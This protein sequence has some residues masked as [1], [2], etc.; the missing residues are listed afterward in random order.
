MCFLSAIGL[1]QAQSNWDVEL[2]P[3]QKPTDLKETASSSLTSDNQ[4]M[5]TKNEKLSEVWVWLHSYSHNWLIQGFCTWYNNKREG[6]CRRG[7]T[8]NSDKPVQGGGSC[9]VVGVVMTRWCLVI[10]P[11]LITFS[12]ECCTLWVQGTNRLKRKW[13]QNR[14]SCGN[15]RFSCIPFPLKSLYKDVVHMLCTVMWKS[16]FT[17]F[18]LWGFYTIR[19]KQIWLYRVLKW[20]QYN[21]RLTKTHDISQCVVFYLT[22]N[23]AK[24]SAPH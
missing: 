14:L 1:T 20:F 12:E 13:G 2:L 24:A 4:L 17:V 5:Q 18:Q 11:W 10:F 22:K 23:K 8:H 16:W 3:V 15:Y 21:L 19:G 7:F 9:G 6:S